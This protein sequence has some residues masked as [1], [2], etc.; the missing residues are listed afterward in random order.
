M[1]E[2]A[3]I[4]A[5]A[6]G[7]GVKVVVDGVHLTPHAPVDLAAIGCDVYSTSSYKWYGPHA[8]ITWI[9]PGLIDRLQAYKVRPAPDA[10]PGK[11]MLGTPAYENMA[12]IEVPPPSS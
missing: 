5:A 3:A 11:F 1:P 4:T 8:G 12:A 2:I 7:A 9:E 10:G 6:H